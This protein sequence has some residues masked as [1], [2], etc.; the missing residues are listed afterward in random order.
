MGWGGE[1]GLCP[2]GCGV[3]PGLWASFIP[4]P[5]LTA[6]TTAQAGV[7]KGAVQ[8]KR[9][10]YR[11]SHGPANP[12][13]HPGLWE[14]ERRE[15]RFIKHPLRLVGWGLTIVSLNPWSCHPPRYACLASKDRLPMGAPG[16]SRRLWRGSRGRLFPLPPLPARRC[17]GF[18]EWGPASCWHAL[19]WEHLASPGPH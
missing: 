4:D 1:G 9:G 17:P 3:G 8:G 18:C 15:P 16:V 7:G 5:A 10:G 19:S 13:T 12:A 14:E 11:T 6:L 2:G